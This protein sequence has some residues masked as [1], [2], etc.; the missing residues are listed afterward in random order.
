MPAPPRLD[1]VCDCGCVKACHRKQLQW[2]ATVY[3]ACRHHPICEQFRPAAKASG[4]AAVS[5]AVGLP[6]LAAYPAYACPV[7]GSRYSIRFTDHGCGDL[8][9][10]TVTIALREDGG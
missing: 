3:A 8:L 1:V 4:T 2:G 9:P 5:A 6:V 10:V 7:C